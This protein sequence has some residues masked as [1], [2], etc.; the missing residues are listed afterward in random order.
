MVIPSGRFAV[1]L[2]A[3]ARQLNSRHPAHGRLPPLFMVT[4]TERMADPLAAA[5]AL[6]RGSGV[7]LRHYDDPDRE[8]LARALGRLARQ[9][10]LVL[11]VAGDGRLAA[12]SGAAGL[13][14]PQALVNEAR[15]WRLQR[16]R[17]LITAAAHDPAALR[18][19][20]SAGADAALL[21]PAFATAS[22]P[23]ATALG[24]MRFVAWTRA[25]PI[26]VYALGGIDDATA[27]R[28][29]GSGAIGIAAVGAFAGD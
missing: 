7:I 16:P 27:K 17:W 14:L 29:A 6:P 3:L 13:H 26:P 12:R 18:R 28:L 20:A 25:S 10:G 1:K 5:R 24:A 19:A 22:H 9:R 15:R 21:S 4:D 8:L 23:G 2:A 11:L